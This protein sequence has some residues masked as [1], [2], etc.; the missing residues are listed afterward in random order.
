MICCP[1]CGAT[2]REGSR[3]CEECGEVLVSSGTRCPMCDT[4]NSVGTTY[5]QECNAR[6]VPMSGAPG[7]EKRGDTKETVQGTALPP[8]PPEQPESEVLEHA[9]QDGELDDSHPDD[10]IAELRGAAIHDPE[11]VQPHDEGKGDEEP[12]G[13]IADQASGM[14]PV[15]EDTERP[16]STAGPPA[17]QPPSDE[18]AAQGESSSGKPRADSAPADE[19]AW[20]RP[21]ED[22]ARSDTEVTPPSEM[23]RSWEP[24]DVPGWLRGIG[25]DADEPSPLP[26]GQ[27]RTSEESPDG[28]TDASQ[29]PAETSASEEAPQ[30]LNGMDSRTTRETSPS[31]PSP[32]EE[33]ESADEEQAMIEF[34][35]WLKEAPASEPPRSLEER[36]E[37]ADAERKIEPD[38]DE[39]P[40]PSPDSTRLDTEIGME[41]AAS[42]RISAE[43]V[44][45]PGWAQETADWTKDE[46]SADEQP[47]ETEADDKTDEVTSVEIRYQTEVL[48]SWVQDVET[49]AEEYSP[50]E[51][52]SPQTAGAPERI[53]APSWLS[54]LLAPAPAEG[55]EP[56][57]LPA[58]PGFS[59]EGWDENLQR[60][61]IP[62]WLL[63]LRPG[64][65][66]QGAVVRGP[67]ESEGLLRGL[68]GVIPGS[69]VSTAPTSVPDFSTPETSEA[70]LARA[71]L[72][73]SLLGQ[74]AA[75]P[76]SETREAADAASLVER[77]LVAGLLVLTVVSR[78]VVLATAPQ[79]PRLTQPLPSPAA[80]SLHGVVDGLGVGDQVLVAFDYGPTEVDELNAAVHPVLEH[81]LDRGATI[82]IV[83]TRPDG[84]VLAEAMMSLV[85]DT[86]DRYTIAGYRP[87]AAAGVSQLLAATDTTPALLLILTGRAMP[88]RLWIEQ[89]SARYG[90]QLPVAAVGSASLEPV[91]SPYLDASAG[92][93]VGAIHGLKGAASYETIRGAPG[94]AAQRLD[95]L[96]AGHMAVVVLIIIG[97][98]VHAVGLTERKET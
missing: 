24:D 87:G 52:M 41:A 12:L 11:D 64:H 10:W 39:G 27:L 32:V 97:S 43:S 81:V 96:A 31:R 69:T 71:E 92:Q 29:S 91:A 84:L 86:Q 42:T 56:S 79:A 21:A 70:S 34:P 44:E 40:S 53:E 77:W 49:R 90:E 95:V 15:R 17:E 18:E 89:A 63:G 38:A 57:P 9:A 75:G 20:P 85:A 16:M 83:S 37:E 7:E 28:E 65:E 66:D 33:L 36:E 30:R 8:L 25:P 46:P 68:R 22:A 50:D 88:L 6:L 3:L 93:L 73:Q 23:N 55:S 45:I 60:A 14:G 80:R 5:C 19:T 54:D 67:V 48:P 98:A 72:L 47:G 78:L 2:N 62:D 35:E 61:D 26:A 59:E 82:S 76:R 58:E 94:E 13:G 1:N 74:P 51:E 4:L